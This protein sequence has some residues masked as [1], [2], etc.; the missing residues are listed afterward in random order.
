MNIREAIET[1]KVLAPY[2]GHLQG[3][4]TLGDAIRNLLSDASEI[5]PVDVLRLIALLYHKDIEAVADEFADKSGGDLVA[6]LAHAFVV[7]PLPDLVNAGY[8][9]QLIGV[10]WESDGRAN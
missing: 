6:A 10:E 4:L 2:A 7:N 1:M 5:N 3:Q 8:R 9:L